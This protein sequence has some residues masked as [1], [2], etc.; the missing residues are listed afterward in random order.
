MPLATLPPLRRHRA[1]L[2]AWSTSAASSSSFS[3]RGQTALEARQLSLHAAG[4]SVKVAY[5]AAEPLSHGWTCF[6]EIHWPLAVSS[7]TRPSTWRSIILPRVNF[8]KCDNLATTGVVM[9]HSVPT[10][11]LPAQS[12][13]PLHPAHRRSGVSALAKFLQMPLRQASCWF[14][15]H[16]SAPCLCAL[17]PS[18]AL[19]GV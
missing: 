10:Y 7:R 11:V 5:V 9:S 18:L 19:A 1:G 3:T 6:R 17:S 2:L 14:L 12:S 13:S 15:W 16:R 4:K 8:P